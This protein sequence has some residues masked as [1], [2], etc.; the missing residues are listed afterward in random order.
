MWA[1]I[2]D[3]AVCEITEIDPAGRFHPAMEWITCD[4][5]VVPGDRYVDGGFVPASNESSAA[6]ER[7]WRDAEI[8]A[9]EWLVSRHRD[10][11]DM[12]LS[13]SLTAEQFAELLTYRQALRDW[14]A[15]V[16]FPDSTQ[17]PVAPAWVAEQNQ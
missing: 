2:I 8:S 5:S 10:E 13:T 15:A 17:R 11:V 1:L 7:G 9:T 3:G 12:Q 6:A 14:P 16:G 4:G